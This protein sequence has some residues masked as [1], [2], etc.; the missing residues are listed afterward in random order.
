MSL[1]PFVFL[2][3]VLAGVIRIFGS[4]AL[5][6]GSQVALLFA[7]ALVVVISM[8]RYRVPWKKT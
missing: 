2:V 3:A 7:S 6:G 1:V 4:D 8:A 5:A